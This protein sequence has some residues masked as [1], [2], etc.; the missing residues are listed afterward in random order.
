MNLVGIVGG[1]NFRVTRPGRRFDL[2]LETRD[3][4]LVPGQPFEGH[5]PVEPAMP[6]L[7]SLPH[8]S[9]A[10]LLQEEIVAQN[11]RLALAAVDFFGLKP[12]QLLLSDQFVRQSFGVFRRS[13]A[14]RIR[15]SSFRPRH[16]SGEPAP[17]IVRGERTYRA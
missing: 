4:G 16:R 3:G 8:P 17:G 10:D 15:S 7:E 2:A 11:Q 9:R 6:G 12:G 1:D 5:E 13:W 14:A